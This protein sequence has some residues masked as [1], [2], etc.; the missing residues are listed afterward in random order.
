MLRLESLGQHLDI[1]S[2]RSLLIFT[3]FLGFFLLLFLLYTLLH[4]LLLLRTFWSLW[5]FGCPL[6]AFGFLGGSTG[7]AKVKMFQDCAKSMILTWPPSSPSCPFW[8]F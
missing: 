4:F 1:A 5:S 6:T 8:I 7:K 3:A 2:E